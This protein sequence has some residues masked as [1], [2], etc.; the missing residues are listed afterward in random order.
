MVSGRSQKQKSA[1]CMIPC[2]DALEYVKLINGESAPNSD[3]LEEGMLAGKECEE[4]SW[5]DENVLYYDRAVI[6]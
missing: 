4:S 5:N 6:T 2:I 1:Y 3:Y